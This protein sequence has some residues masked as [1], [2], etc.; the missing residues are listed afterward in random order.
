MKHSPEK[1]QV[2]ERI[3]EEAIDDSVKRNMT[4]FA[5]ASF[6][7]RYP[8]A[9]DGLKPIARRIIYSMHQQ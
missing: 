7:D 5:K 1:E 6:I 4:E 3:I 2:I 9:R 8:D